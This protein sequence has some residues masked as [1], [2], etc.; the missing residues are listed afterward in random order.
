MNNVTYKTVYFGTVDSK[1]AK[2]LLESGIM[3][4]VVHEKNEDNFQEL[5]EHVKLWFPLWNIREGENVSVLEPSVDNDVDFI[6]LGDGTFPVKNTI[7]MPNNAIY[8]LEDGSEFNV[9]EE[10]IK[11]LAELGIYRDVIKTR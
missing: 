10:A 4:T 1:G 7:Y 5:N 8:M 9:K 2:E 6:K 3:P 11:D